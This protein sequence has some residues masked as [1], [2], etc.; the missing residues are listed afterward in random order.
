MRVGERWLILT[1]L[2]AEQ[3]RRDKSPNKSSTKSVSSELDKKNW[4]SE[5]LKWRAELEVSPGFAPW[6]GDRAFKGN[7]VPSSTGRKRILD[8]IDL[9]AME[10]CKRAKKNPRV[11][12]DTMAKI[13]NKTL[14]DVSQ[15]HKRRAFSN[16]DGVASCLCTGSSL[17][18]Y[19]LDRML[20]ASEHLLMQGHSTSLV[21]PSSFS[22]TN[23]RRIAGESIALPCLGMLIWVLY[24][25]VGF[26]A[27]QP[28]NVIRNSA[29]S[30]PWLARFYEW[31]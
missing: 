24:T 20:M 19:S 11:S 13:V 29:P 14:V 7:G 30:A 31:F 17:Y 12:R 28:M 25:S 2:E 6:T 1:P 15:S 16:I 3:R 22:K 26:P 4:P 10:C 18:S 9:A 23:V 8:L 21:I 27:A 5:S